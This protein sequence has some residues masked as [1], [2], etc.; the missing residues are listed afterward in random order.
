MQNA[1]NIAEQLE[2]LAKAQHSH[3]FLHVYLQAASHRCSE[4]AEWFEG[5][6]ETGTLSQWPKTICTRK[7]VV[8]SLKLCHVGVQIRLLG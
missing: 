4:L 3:G 2:L 5:S 7:H 1:N 8:H 6:F